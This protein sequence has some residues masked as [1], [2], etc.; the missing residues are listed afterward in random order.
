MNVFTVTF[1][2]LNTS[3]LNTININNFFKQKQS[4]WPKLLSSSSLYII[5]SYIVAIVY[6]LVGNWKLIW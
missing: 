5:L 2:Q 4:F 1:D 6:E 3:L